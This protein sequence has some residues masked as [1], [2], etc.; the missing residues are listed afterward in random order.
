MARPDPLGPAEAFEA[1]QRL[2]EIR[3]SIGWSSHARRRARERNFSADDVRRVLVQ[4]RMSGT[5][6][7]NET[8]QN[9]TYKVC[10]RDYD[11]E[12]LAVV[13]ALEPENGRLTLITGEDC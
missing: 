1:I 5:A 8:F 6:E 13:I 3:D 2:L 9:W 7:W 4:G 11:N 12:P 10:G